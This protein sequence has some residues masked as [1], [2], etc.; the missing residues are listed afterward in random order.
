MNV[1]ISFVLRH[2][3]YL[4]NFQR[5]T[6]RELW[7]YT[8]PPHFS[9]PILYFIISTGKKHFLRNA[10]LA[11]LLSTTKSSIPSTDMYYLSQIIIINHDIFTIIYRYPL[12]ETPSQKATHEFLDHNAHSQLSLSLDL[13]ILSF[14]SELVIFLPHGTG[15]ASCLILFFAGVTN[16]LGS[17]KFCVLSTHIF[18]YISLCYYLSLI[19]YLSNFM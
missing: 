2:F 11:N 9:Q 14:I 17:A 8:E 5:Y 15:A 1:L 7:D 13:L 10:L 19:I 3:L 12:K 4:I 16:H 18:F 6:P